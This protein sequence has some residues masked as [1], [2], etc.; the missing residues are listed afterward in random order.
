[1]SCLWCKDESMAAEMIVAFPAP[2]TAAVY[3]EKALPDLFHCMDCVVVY[4]KLKDKFTW[5][6][7]EQQVL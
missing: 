7:R 4:H 2:D 5:T 1:M 3:F 6:E